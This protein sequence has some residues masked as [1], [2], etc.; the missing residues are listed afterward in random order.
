MILYKYVPF[1]SA[2]KIIETCSIGFS[3]AEHFNDPFELQ[4]LSFKVSGN[5]SLDNISTGAVRNRCN[6]AYSVLSLT[7]QPLNSLMWS[8]YGD[9]HRGVVIGIDIEEAGYTCTESNVIP[10]TYGEIIYTKTKPHHKIESPNV[11]ELMAIGDDISSF[12]DNNY[13]LF[14]RAYLYKSSEWFYEEE[15][16]VVKNTK[17]NNPLSKYKEGKY[18]NPAGDWNQIQVGGRALFCNKIPRGAFKEIHIGCNIY[19]N[20]SRAGLKEGDVFGVL[21]KWKKDGLSISICTPEHHTWELHTKE[22]HI[23]R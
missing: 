22:W 13:D 21:S 16:R 2:K 11:D 15:V 7:R 1:E 4:A 20:V 14:K 19:K 23:P 10:A 5:R 3:S 12:T 18:T 17:I 6:S 9:S 8:H